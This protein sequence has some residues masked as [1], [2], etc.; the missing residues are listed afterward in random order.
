MGNRVR[1][2]AIWLLC[3]VAA[4]YSSIRMLW[5]V[6]ANP[7]R[8]WLLYQSHDQLLNAA[9]GG[10]PDLTFLGSDSPFTKPVS[11]RTALFLL[12]VM[13][14][15][16]QLH[17]AARMALLIARN[18]IRAWVMAVSFDQLANA[19]TNGNR[20]ETISSRANRARSEGR[21]WGC[22]LCRILD[23]VDE[24]HCMHAAGI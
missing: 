19:A 10:D 2:I 14:M 15:V 9:E 6:L 7:A 22:L 3:M 11:A 4:A 24:N 20:R 18:P 5:A 21:R 23:W 12:W 17:C 13:C 16:I 1:L 8:A